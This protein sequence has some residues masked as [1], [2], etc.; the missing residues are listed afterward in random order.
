MN[1]KLE[2]RECLDEKTYIYYII[3]IMI[4]YQAGPVGST[5][6]PNLLTTITRKKKQN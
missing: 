1:K 4:T 6:N 5:T 2:K 3:L